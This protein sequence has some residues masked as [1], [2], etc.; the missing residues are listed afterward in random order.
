[1]FREVCAFYRQ[2][3]LDG[4]HSSPNLR[5][6][7]TLPNTLVYIIPHDS[8]SGKRI[9][10][11]FPDHKHNIEVVF[12]E[13]KAGSLRVAANIL[14]HATRWLADNV[15]YLGK[16]PRDQQLRIIVWFLMYVRNHPASTLLTRQRPTQIP[17]GLNQD[18]HS[19]H[20]DQLETWDNLNNAWLALGQKQLGLTDSSS[21]E[22]LLWGK[23]ERMGEFIIERSNALERHGLVDYQRGLMEEQIL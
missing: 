10:E 1:M 6:Q 21:S 22:V 3:A 7:V 18:N 9:R 23:I 15:V 4:R 2:L 13:I 12:T 5:F 8:D 16:L 17:P 11:V 20:I 14:G 19:D